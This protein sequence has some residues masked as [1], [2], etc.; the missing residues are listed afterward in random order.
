MLTEIFYHT[1]NFCK[2]YEK[3]LKK[4]GI[5]QGKKDPRGRR[6][7]L[8]LSEIMTIAICFHHSK[9]KTFKNYYLRLRMEHS[10]DFTKLVSYNRFV[11]LQK[12]II[13]PLMLF[14]TL[15][16]A[17]NATGISFIDSTKLQVCDN[18]RI[19]SHKVFKGLAARGKT[20]MGWFYGFKLHLI[21]NEYGEIVAFQITPG[22]VLDNNEKVV[23]GMSKNICGKIFGDKGYVSQKNFESL[24]NRGLQLI[25]KIKKGMKNKLMDV[26]DKLLLKRRGVIESVNNILKNCCTLEHSRHRSVCNFFVNVLSALGAY[27]FLDKKPSVRGL[28]KE[29]I[30][31]K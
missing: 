3:Y 22:N 2:E 30:G 20:S 12:Q 11:E 24:W 4:I 7:S 17:E 1:D 27:M 29:L 14:L 13:I 26:Y 19:Y 18:R 15:S 28:K 23:Q 5:N 31:V 25:T 6:P 21:I 9:M 8:C 10:A 16:C